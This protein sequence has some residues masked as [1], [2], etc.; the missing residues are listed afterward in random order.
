MSDLFITVEAL[1]TKPP[2]NVKHC[3][4]HLN[5]FHPTRNT[6]PQQ[7]NDYSTNEKRYL[8]RRHMLT[9]PRRLTV[10][11]KMLNIYTSATELINLLIEK[12]T[13][14]AARW[15]PNYHGAGSQT[16]GRIIFASYREAS[17]NLSEM[18][19]IPNQLNQKFN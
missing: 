10:Q 14:R 15:W 6:R 11:R 5:E 19:A 4:D 8:A 13:H 7:V 9:I 18:F 2:E 16:E 17:A 12:I 1:G 3:L